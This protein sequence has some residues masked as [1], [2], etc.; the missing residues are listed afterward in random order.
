MIRWLVAI[1]A[2]FIVAGPTAA[3]HADVRGGAAKDSDDQTARPDLAQV[4]V[5]YDDAG[6]IA[7]AARFYDLI[8]DTQPSSLLTVYV[9]EGLKCSDEKFVTIET[10]TTTAPDAEARVIGGSA[11]EVQVDK[12]VAADGRTIQLVVSGRDLKR[13]DYRCVDAGLSKEGGDEFFDDLSFFFKGYAPKTLPTMTTPR[14]RGYARRAIRDYLEYSPKVRPGCKAQERVKQRCRL[15]WRSGNLL[16]RGAV[17]VFYEL[18]SDNKVTW[19]YRI[20]LERANRRC[21]RIFGWDFCS[22]EV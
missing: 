4:N 14:A 19:D 12:Q 17:V 21:V 8:D 13:R 9:S 20:A 1:A 15:N 3:A 5:L 7:V 2:A 11:E 6:T 10:S 18:T 22:E 16:Y